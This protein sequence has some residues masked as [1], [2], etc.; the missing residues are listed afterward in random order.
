MILNTSLAKELIWFSA[1][2]SNLILYSYDD[3]SDLL[4]ANL[5]FGKQV[6][7]PLVLEMELVKKKKNPGPIIKAAFVSALEAY[8]KYKNGVATTRKFTDKTALRLRVLQGDLDEIIKTEKNKDE[9]GWGYLDKIIGIIHRIKPEHLLTAGGVQFKDRNDLQLALGSKQSCVEFYNLNFDAFFKK[10]NDPKLETQRILLIN[11][12][13][14]LKLCKILN[15]PAINDWIEKE[16]NS[17][18]DVI[19]ERI[20]TKEDYEVDNQFVYLNK[21]SHEKNN[22]EKDL[23]RIEKENKQLKIELEQLHSTTIKDVALSEKDLLIQSLKD[24]LMLLKEVKAA[25][26]EKNAD[27]TINELVEI[28]SL[29]TQLANKEAELKFFLTEREEKQKQLEEKT[30]LYELRKTEIDKHKTEILRVS[31]NLDA[32]QQ[33]YSASLIRIRTTQ[34]QLADATEKNATLQISLSGIKSKPSEIGNYLIIEKMQATIDTLNEKILNQ[35]KLI[36]SSFVQTLSDYEEERTKKI[37]KRDDFKVESLISQYP[38]EETAFLDKIGKQKYCVMRELVKDPVYVALKDAV[39]LEQNFE[40]YKYGHE[41]DVKKHAGLFEELKYKNAL[42]ENVQFDVESSVF[43]T[44]VNTAVSKMDSILDQ[45]FENAKR[46]LEIVDEKITKTSGQ[47]KQITDNTLMEIENKMKE[48]TKAKKET[49]KVN[50]T[51]LGQYSDTKSEIMNTIA[52]A[53]MD[54]TQKASLTPINNLFNPMP[55]PKIET[56]EIKRLYW[57]VKKNCLVVGDL[58]LFSHRNVTL[59]VSEY[60]NPSL[61]LPYDDRMTSEEGEMQKF[62]NQLGH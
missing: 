48:Y 38:K 2:F 11:N 50:K 20:I 29:K 43:Q 47:L 40:D 10:E 1:T 61:R 52:E 45:R 44:F 41:I 59:T 42:L 28:I 31:N 49:T 16:V 60:F 13:N 21:V 46:S 54:L 14:I 18:E 34:E 5:K 33:K 55:T 25:I 12:L 58:V 9:I 19:M 27:K 56:K 7:I 37:V 15:K 39:T 35:A 36:K 6:D 3:W 26:S 22:L 4:K 62:Y 17:E 23:R 57:P 53:K 8:A 30:N 24:E 51:G 32:L